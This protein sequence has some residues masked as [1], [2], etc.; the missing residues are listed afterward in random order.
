[1]SET[2]RRQL[3]GRPFRL[4]WLSGAISGT[5]DGMFL[6]AFPLLAAALTRDALVIAGVTVA[7][8][9]PWLLFSL[10]TGAI[11][12]RFDRRRLMVLADLARTVV[13]GLLGVA[14]LTGEA[15]VWLL[16]VCAFGLGLGET[17]HANSAQSIIPVIVD[18]SVLVSA[19]ARLTGTQVLTESFCGPPLG[20]AL[21]GIAPAAP[22]LVDAASF[23]ASA[24]LVSAMPDV[25]RR[26]T[27]ST[28]M[29]TDIREGVSF[30][31]GHPV[32]RRLA[33]LLGILNFFYFATEAVLILYALEQLHAGKGI[34]A[35]MFLAGA[36]GTLATQWLVT[37]LQ[38]RIGAGPTIT[39]SFWLWAIALVGLCITST[40]AIAIAMYFVLGA[41][42]GLWRVLTVTLRQTLTPNRLLGRVNAAYRMVGQGVIP[43][44]AAFGGAIAK[45]FGIRAPFV[46]A[47]VVFVVIAAA[48][49]V[50]LRPAR[51]L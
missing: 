17:L 39:I 37:P 23:A 27:P 19:N 51:G 32:L 24:G 38:Q 44:G 47:A 42:D 12:D 1:V 30:T 50:L 22:F 25:H 4:V 21:F 9:L 16:Y 3:L 46:V 33:A 34:Y 40:P 28:R 35:V 6:T 14:V 26:E 48:G 8:R 31:L 13:V 29:W 18:P 43:L 10:V 5:G 7:S 11:A 36:A 45:A 49:P 20:A 15:E 2:D 41:G